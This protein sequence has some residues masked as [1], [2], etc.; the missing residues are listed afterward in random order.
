MKL[1]YS[2]QELDTIIITNLIY[3]LWKQRSMKP[4]IQ[5]RIGDNNSYNLIK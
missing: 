2:R 1:S 5:R 4:A 3:N